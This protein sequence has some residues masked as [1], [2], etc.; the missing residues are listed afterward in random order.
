MWL[1]G[2]KPEWLAQ[3]R[4]RKYI[5]HVH[6]NDTGPAHLCDLVPG[7]V[8]AYHDYEPWF[9]LFYKAA[10][11]LPRKAGLPDFSCCLS[12]ELEACRETRMIGSAYYRTKNMLARFMADK[13]R[14][15]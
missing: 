5:S 13:A 2:I 3:G 10:N 12:V 9:D 4:N 11:D 6:I 14:L 15:E 8:H 7:T 1:C